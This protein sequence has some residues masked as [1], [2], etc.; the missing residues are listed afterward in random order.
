MPGSRNVVL[1]ESLKAPLYGEDARG[2]PQLVSRV[3]SSLVKADAVPQVVMQKCRNRCQ[4]RSK[5]E[6]GWGT[7]RGF[8]TKSNTGAR[9]RGPACGDA[10]AEVEN[11]VDM[12]RWGL[13]E[14]SRRRGADSRYLLC[15]ELATRDTSNISR[16]LNARP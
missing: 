1:Y 9:S 5:P 2:I 11:P 6:P 14:V 4:T 12:R 8:A 10:T 15:S 7:W 13:H 3:V 16:I